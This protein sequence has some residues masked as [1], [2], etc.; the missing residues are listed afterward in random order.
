MTA[1]QYAVLQYVPDPVRQESLNVGV[2]VAIPGSDTAAV[3]MLKKPEAAR[4]KWLGVKDDI[5]FLDD[6][7]DDLS[8]PEVP[9]GGTAADVLARAHTEWGGTVRVSELR[10][11][12]HDDVQDLCDELYSRYVAN[13]RTRK[14]AAYRDRAAARRT[15]ATALREG[16]PKEAV[17]TRVTVPGRYEAHRFDLGLRNGKLLHAIATFSFEAPDREAL[18]TEVDACAWAIQDV[19]KATPQLPIT[20]VT[21]GA[22]ERLNAAEQMYHEVGARLIREPHIEEWARGVTSELEPLLGQNAPA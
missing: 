2:V 1:F 16:L 6:L 7:A 14:R 20:V 15:V 19:R 13:P 10:A 18:Q 11:A 12:L 22:G 17:Q 9:P 21:I 5:Q 4:L 8:H 3:R